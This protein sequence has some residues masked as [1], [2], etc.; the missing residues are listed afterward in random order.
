MT[1]FRTVLPDLVERGVRLKAELRDLYADAQEKGIDDQLLTK[2]VQ[3]KS[4]S[5]TDPLW[6]PTACDVLSLL[7]GT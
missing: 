4:L 7:N 5:P 2:L 1:D 3:L 6:L